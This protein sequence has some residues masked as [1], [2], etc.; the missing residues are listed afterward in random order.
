MGDELGLLNDRGW[1]DDP[2]HAGDNRWV[3]RPRMPWPVPTDTHGIR[4]GLVHLLDV[5]RGLP[6]LHAATPTEVWDPRDP[7]VLLVVRALAGHGPLLAAANMTDRPAR[8]E[9]RLPLARHGGRRPARP[10]DRRRPTFDGEAITLAPYAAAWLTA[11]PD[12][13]RLSCPPCP[14]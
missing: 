8:A 14:R 1:A 9:R 10:P 4:E 11:G 13:P 5:R 2:A 12:R 7:G 6:H 3:H